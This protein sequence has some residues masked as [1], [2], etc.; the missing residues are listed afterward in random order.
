ME[1]LGIVPENACGMES[2]A[3]PKCIHIF[4]GNNAK[5]NWIDGK[6]TV[7]KNPKESNSRFSSLKR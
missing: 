7:A 3:L 1:I 6:S 2:Y 5:W 4:K